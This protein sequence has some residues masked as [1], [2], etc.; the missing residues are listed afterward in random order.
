MKHKPVS[1][2]RFTALLLP[3]L[4]LAGC[5]DYEL[6]GVVV[7]GTVPEV[8]VVSSDD[9]RLSQNGLAHAQ[10]IGTIDPQSLTAER[11]RPAVADEQGRF[12]ITVTSTGAGLLEYKIGIFARHTGFSPTTD[13]FDL[14]ASRKRLLIVLTPGEDQQPPP[15][16]DITDDA[17]K[18]QEQMR[19]D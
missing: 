8:R 15:N 2:A 10:V 1:S 14:P 3:L 19:R 6:Q 17:L 4:L 12:S 13:T 11:M 16:R 9:P 7:T 5:S 18:A